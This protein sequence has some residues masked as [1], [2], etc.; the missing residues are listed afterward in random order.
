MLIGAVSVAAVL[1]ALAYDR[2]H[3]MRPARPYE[4]GQRG[5]WPSVLIATQGSAYKDAVSR[6]LVNQ[7]AARPAHLKVIDVSELAPVLEREWDA[8]VLLFS[9]ERWQ[10]EPH[11]RTFIGRCSDREKLVVLTT[12]GGGDER[13]PCVDTV[14][15]ASEL[16]RADAD[17]AELARR[18]EAVLGRGNAHRAREQVKR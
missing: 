13:L 12:S 9:W 10:P 17:A 5:A 11:S 15:S 14:T 3:S 1:F 4:S 6:A 2:L 16:T 7:L 8:V 18:V